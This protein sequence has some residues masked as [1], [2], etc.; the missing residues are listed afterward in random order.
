MSIWQYMACVDGYVEANSTEDNQGMAQAEYDAVS[1][2]VLAL[3]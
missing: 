3:S 2:D 1:A